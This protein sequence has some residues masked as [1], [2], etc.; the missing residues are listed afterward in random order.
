MKK[1]L[2]LIR[3][4]VK[5]VAAGWILGRVKA[6]VI[7]CHLPKRIGRFLIIDTL[8][9]GVRRMFRPN[10][11]FRLDY[12][13]MFRK[14]PIAANTLLLLCEITNGNG[15]VETNPEELATLMAARF[16]DSREYAL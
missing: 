15:Q 8:L 16:E 9:Q 10:R 7:D 2:N 5:V 1:L 14:D 13:R 11:K 6:M 12:R 3:L 4:K